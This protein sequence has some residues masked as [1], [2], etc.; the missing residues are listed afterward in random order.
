[1][2]NNKYQ[3]YFAAVLCVAL[4]CA[5]QWARQ[6]FVNVAM[7]A[8]GGGSGIAE[9]EKFP[10]IAIEV[11][12]APWGE[13]TSSNLEKEDEPCHEDDEDCFAASMDIAP[14]SIEMAE[15]SIGGGISLTPFS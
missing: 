14:R 7:E 12:K 1:M 13:K 10:Q 6:W 9:D 11:P 4:F 8:F 3:L 2:G 5:D 15:I